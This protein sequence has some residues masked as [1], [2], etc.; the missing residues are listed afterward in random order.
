MDR[1]LHIG[2]K[3]KAL[4]TALAQD[5]NRSTAAL[6]LTGS[7][8]FFLSYLIRNRDHPVYSKDLEREFDFSHPTVSGVL[9]RLK[10]KGFIVFQPGEK[11]KRCKQILVTGK[12]MECHAMMVR[13]LHE[14]ED[15]VTTGM[16]TQEIQDLHRLL[17]IA[18][19]NMGVT[20][21]QKPCPKQEDQS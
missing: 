9:R 12:A 13:H 1:S 16:T 2:P 8:S 11:D 14:T 4:S 18:M 6:G 10:L 21:S 5:M 7:Q 15:K 3:I 17:E 19:R 20:L